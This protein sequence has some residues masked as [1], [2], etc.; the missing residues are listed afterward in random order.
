MSIYQGGKTA[1]LEWTVYK[2]D[3]PFEHRR[4]QEIWNESP[5]GFAW[6]YAGLGPTKLALALLLDQNISED[7]AFELYQFF[8][9]DVVARWDKDQGWQITSEE[10]LNWIG[11]KD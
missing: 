8:K 1:P 3:S 10:I 6:G 9:R 2:D 4:S 7:R 11:Q 5:I